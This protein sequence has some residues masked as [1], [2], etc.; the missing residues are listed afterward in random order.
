MPLVKL[1]AICPNYPFFCYI[2]QLSQ[3]RAT[4]KGVDIILCM[5]FII[6]ILKLSRD[7]AKLGEG[8][9]SDDEIRRERDWFE[10]LLKQNDIDLLGL[11]SGDR[12]NS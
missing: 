10:S 1:S 5:A 4:T 2:T 8:F 6:V 3:S 11:P 7:L 12:K 9:A